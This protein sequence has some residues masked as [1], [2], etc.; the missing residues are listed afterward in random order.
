MTLGHGIGVNYRLD[1]TITF[2]FDKLLGNGKIFV[3]TNYTDNYYKRWEID[4]S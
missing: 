3:E 4:V 2:H 1:F